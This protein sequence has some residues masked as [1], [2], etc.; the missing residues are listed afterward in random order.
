[1]KKRISGPLA[2]AVGLGFSAVAHGAGYTQTVQS[3]P[4]LRAYYP[5]STASGSNSVVNGYTGTFVGSAAVGAAGTGPAIVDHPGNT[6]VALNGNASYVNTN[7][8]GGINSAGSIVGWFNL[9]ALPSTVGHIETIAG[10]SQSGN[11]FDLQIE[12]NTVRFYTDGGSYTAGPTLTAA[13]LNQWIFV[14]A[15]FTSATDRNVYIG[16]G[17]TLTAFSSVPGGHGTGSG[18]F[19]IGESDVF[20]GRYFNGAIDEVAVY[21]TDLTAGQVSAIYAS[22][23][24][25][26]P[27]PASA[28]LAAL[29][30][31]AALARRR[32][33]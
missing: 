12:G 27:E 14:A 5:F 9:S 19:A 18:T 28:T 8:V 4:G 15:T 33:V 25:A 29:A 26:V 21:N 7:L 23:N 17:G 16:E 3:T 2:A 20:T 13:D 10:Q 30:A 6:P 22:R 24:T 32:R 1:M 11:D 31:G